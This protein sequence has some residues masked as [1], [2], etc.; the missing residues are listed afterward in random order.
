VG[1]REA[2]DTRAVVGRMPLGL[3]WIDF[4]T[5]DEAHQRTR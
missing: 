1:A 2:L 3:V 4:G 5:P